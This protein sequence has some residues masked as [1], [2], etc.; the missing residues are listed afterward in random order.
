MEIEKRSKYPFCLVQFR[1]Y[2]GIRPVFG[3]LFLLGLI[4][5][6]GGIWGFL[7]WENSWWRPDSVARPLFI[8]YHLL[9]FALIYCITWMIFDRR[10]IEGYVFSLFSI[11]LGVVYL[12]S[13]ID[14]IPDVM[15]VIG[16]WDDL[17]ISFVS[18][19]IGVVAFRR[20][21]ARVDV[22][23]RAEVMARKGEYE[24]ALKTIFESEGYVVKD[25]DPA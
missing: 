11:V 8:L 24:T 10:T 14:I 4:Y 22:M 21:Q 6:L 16:T 2:H 20:G 25:R 15:P 23:E 1:Q 9:V 7:S 3:V 13:P 19:F 5:F 17:F 12:L 18:I